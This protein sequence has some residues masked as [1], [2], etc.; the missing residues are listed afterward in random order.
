MLYV[1]IFS[2]PAGSHARAIYV[3]G[4]HVRTGRR[5]GGADASWVSRALTM[6]Y[7][8]EEDEH[9]LEEGRHGEGGRRHR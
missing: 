4:E 5:E 3:K 2:F 7:G 8:E 6:G 9:R 1:R